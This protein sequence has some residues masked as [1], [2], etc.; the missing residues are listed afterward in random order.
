MQKDEVAPL[1]H[2]L[3]APK[4]TVVVNGAASSVFS[5]RRQR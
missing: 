4:K 3:N 5:L 1:A 2:L